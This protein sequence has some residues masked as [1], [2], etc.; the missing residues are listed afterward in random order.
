MKFALILAMAATVMSLVAAADDLSSYVALDTGGVT[1]LLVAYA[2][3]DG[4]NNIVSETLNMQAKGMNVK[5]TNRHDFKKKRSLKS[6]GKGKDGG[7]GK[8]AKAKGKEKGSR[9]LQEGASTSGYSVIEIASDDFK[10]DVHTLSKV[11]GVVAI[12][13]DATM[14]VLSTDY[15]KKL[16]GGSATDHMNDIQEAIKTAADQL[17]V[18]D[19]AKNGRRL[20]EESPYGIGMVRADEVWGEDPPAGAQPITICVVDTG[21]DDG[22]DDLPS[23]TA[24]GVDG[25]TPSGSTY[26]GQVWSVDGHGH[27]THCAGTI[28]AIGE[29]D[30]GV[31][32]VNPDPSKFK[33]YIGKGLSDSGSGTG[34]G[35]MDSVQACVD[36]GAK[37]ISMSLGG[38]GFSPTS[39]AQYQE[40]YDDNGKYYSPAIPY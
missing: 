24:H 1:T 34:A 23:S 14:H 33:F 39:N 38:G 22:H 12:E 36:A 26:S 11:K 18:E 6:K 35:V 5:E 32:S 4:H 15:Q 7:K 10:A 29:N 28:G 21:Y 8:K 13:V 31:T 25:F 17:S 9:F 37:V 40:H 2:D 20:A 16:R 3:E 27:G 19:E 30:I